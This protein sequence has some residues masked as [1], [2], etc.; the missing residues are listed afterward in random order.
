MAWAA[1]ASGNV[2]RTL[3]GGASWTLAGTTPPITWLGGTTPSIREMRFFDSQNGWAVTW[4]SV[5][6]TTDGG[7]T[8]VQHLETAEAFYTS[9]SFINI[10]TGWVVSERGAYLSTTDGGATWNGVDLGEFNGAWVWRVRFINSQT[11]WITCWRN[12]GRNILKTIDGG[13]TWNQQ[14]FISG[15]FDFTLS[16]IS[17]VSATRAW[18]A[19]RT[20]GGE[21]L[22]CA[23]GSTWTVVD[24]PGATQINAV[25]FVD[26]NVG[27]A[28]G[29]EIYKT[30]NG[31]ATWT[32]Q[33]ASNLWF[34][35]VHLV[36]SSTGWVAGE[37][38]VILKTTTGGD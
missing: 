19:G 26:A 24:I 34:T 33:E 9:I 35:D 1:T 21:L 13:A 29:R 20:T 27:W 37:N 4:N 22:A 36:S 18:I 11:G 12:G 31:G 6:R 2:Y 25:H 5:L 7:Q 17:A 32:E 23:D 16:D 38:G 28:V 30:T 15:D 8:W 10:N 3:D 14:Y